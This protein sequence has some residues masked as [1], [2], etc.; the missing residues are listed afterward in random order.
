MKQRYISPLIMLGFIIILIITA[1]V[2]AL[3]GFPVIT[4][5][6]TYISIASFDY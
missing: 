1:I 5:D 4:L 2:A 3:F 6:E